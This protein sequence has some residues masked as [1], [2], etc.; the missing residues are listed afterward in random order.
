MPSIPSFGSAGSLVYLWQLR[1]ALEVVVPVVALPLGWLL[2]GG[3][4]ILLVVLVQV[5]ILLVW[6]SYLEVDIVTLDQAHL[7][8]WVRLILNLAHGVESQLALGKVFV[9]YNTLELDAK[10]QPIQM[11]WLP[12]M[13]SN[14]KAL[15]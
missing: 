11:V 3:M 12:E 6:P 5:A 1:L 14:G 4:A 13:K 9:G 8:P 15:G 10:L 2:L 7:W